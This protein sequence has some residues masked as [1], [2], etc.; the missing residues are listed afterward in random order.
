M[1]FVLS[2]LALLLAAGWFLRRQLTGLLLP[3]SYSGNLYLRHEL[4]GHGVDVSRLSSPCVAELT[5]EIVSVAKIVSEA[6]GK[7]WR[8]DIT[9]NIE[10]AALIVAIRLNVCDAPLFIREIAN[11]SLADDYVAILRKHGVMVA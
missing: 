11:G 10:N 5:S 7:N 8:Q 2:G 4:T 6:S 1:G 3:I 9:N